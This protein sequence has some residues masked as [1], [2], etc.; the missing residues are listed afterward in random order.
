MKTL[1]TVRLT[2]NDRP[3][4]LTHLLALDRE[5]RQMRFGFAAR[6]SSI[7]RYVNDIDF[8]RDAVFGVK[9]STGRPRLFDGI[10]HLALGWHHAEIGVTVLAPARGGGIGS[11]LM[12]CAAVHTRKCGIETLFMQSLARNPGIIRIATSLGMKVVTTAATGK[13]MPPLQPAHPEALKR[14]E[15]IECIALYDAALLQAV[16]PPIAQ[17]WLARSTSDGTLGGMLR[18]AI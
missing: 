11:A 15:D 8:E 4:L 7:E 6:D 13:S 5:E 12:S 1:P 16:V 3:A 10:V 14:A 18:K 17:G 2:K 9:Q